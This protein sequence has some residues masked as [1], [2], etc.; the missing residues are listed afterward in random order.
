VNQLDVLTE[1]MMPT[2]SAPGAMMFSLL[3]TAHVLQGRLE[4]ALETAGLSWPKYGVLSQLAGAKEPVP[5]SELA[6]GNSCVRS[7]MTQ[8]V[9]RLEADG[10]VR[11]V[12]DPSDRRIVRAAI[13]P[14]GVERQ[15]EGTRQMARVQAKFAAS[16]PD[17][18]RKALRRVLDALKE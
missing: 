2:E 9:D 17:A 1:A 18:D 7:N 10:L 13:T 5:L 16:L 11:R 12:D 3:E 8:L 4:D 14:L 6:E 15:K